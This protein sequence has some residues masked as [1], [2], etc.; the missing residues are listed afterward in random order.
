VGDAEFQKKS[1]ER[2]EPFRA[3]GATV[4]MVSHNLPSIQKL[5]QRA[6]W[7]D[8]GQLRAVG[9]VDEVAARYQQ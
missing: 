8:H 1:G 3:A 6:V 7:L 2:L 9:P 4:L 5:C